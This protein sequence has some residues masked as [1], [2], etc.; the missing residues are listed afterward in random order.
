MSSIDKLKNFITEI[1][2]RGPPERITQKYL[3]SVGYK[4][5][6]DRRII[7]ILKHINLINDD[8]TP[9]ENYLKFRDATVSKSLM[10]SLIR[11]A[12]SALFTDFPEAQKEDTKALSNWFKTKMD[13]GEETANYAAN[14]F[15]ALC[16]FADF[17]TEIKEKPKEEVIELPTEGLKIKEGERAAERPS[18]GIVLNVNIQIVLPATENVEVYDKIFKSLKE[19]ILDRRTE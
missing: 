1:S 15:K 7:P 4:S 3:E 9:N 19:N 5:T 13:V 10:T 2:S 12:Y 8:G 18:T 14:T 6:N 17:E 16:E 11:T